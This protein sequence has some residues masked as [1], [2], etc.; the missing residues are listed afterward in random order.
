MRPLGDL[1]KE[2]SF[3]SNGLILLAIKKEQKILPPGTIKELVS[4]RQSKLEKEQGRL[5]KRAE[6]DSLK[7]VVTQ[8]LLPKALSNYGVTM[9]WIRSKVPPLYGRCLQPQKSRGSCGIR[10]VKLSVHSR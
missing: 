8:E 2:L 6:I 5:L 7:D 4:Q 3:Q 1:S 9:L 10:S